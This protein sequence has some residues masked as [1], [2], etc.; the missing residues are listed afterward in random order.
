MDFEHVQFAHVKRRRAY[1]W[2]EEAE[3]DTGFQADRLVYVVP[4]LILACPRRS[5]RSL[6]GP[7]CGQEGFGCCY[8]HEIPVIVAYKDEI[9]AGYRYDQDQSSRRQIL[10]S[11]ASPAQVDSWLGPPPPAPNQ[12]ILDAARMRRAALTQ[13]KQQAVK[14]DQDALVPAVKS[15]TGPMNRRGLP[16]LRALNAHLATLGLGPITRTQRNQLWGP[17]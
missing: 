3:S 11:G 2:I 12:S 5:G 1:R 4:D 16:K 9:Y 8:E 13:A 14:A 10:E 7:G 15:Y 17:V 6:C